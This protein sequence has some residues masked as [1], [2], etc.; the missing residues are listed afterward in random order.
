M[1]LATQN[2]YLVS[3]KFMVDAA[4]TG[5]RAESTIILSTAFASVSKPRTLDSALLPSNC[6]LNPGL[7]PLLQ[8]YF[9]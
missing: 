9:L 7:G 6:C 2:L 5:S 1:V 3:A 8:L 4:H